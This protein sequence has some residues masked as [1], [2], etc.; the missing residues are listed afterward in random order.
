MT[1]R[2]FVI[3]AM[4]LTT[5]NVAC[6]SDGTS[7]KDAVTT[8]DGTDVQNPTDTGTDSPQDLGPT[9]HGAADNPVTV[10]TGNDTGATDTTPADTVPTDVPA[11]C[12]AVITGPTCREIAACALQCTDAA[13]QAECVG[14]TTG[15]EKTK[16]E[17]L[18]DC[19]ALA[20]CPKI[21]D[22]EQFSA[23]ATA[24]CKDSLDACFQTPDGKCCATVNCRK[25][26]DPDDPSCPMR[27][28]GLASL[29]EQEVFIE[30]KDCL[31]G[32]DCASDVQANLWP[33]W[34]CEN[35]ARYHNCPNQSQACFPLSG[36]N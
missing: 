18:R 30:Y 34:T 29:A 4:V 19:L 10:D 36:C 16:Y 20:A 12:P 6:S 9:D 28:Y 11:T 2:W 24:A 25:D 26:C 7:K 14:A 1:T 33:T 13:H 32:A 3:L 15:D 8:D 35:Y 21:F 23:C 31:L 17:T 5:V 27:C 22:N